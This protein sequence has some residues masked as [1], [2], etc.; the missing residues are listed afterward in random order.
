MIREKSCGAVIWVQEKDTRRYLIERM[1]KGHSSLCKGHMEGEETEHE[2]ALREIGEETALQVTFCGGFR[3][4]ISYSPYPGC[5]KQ[6]VFF[7]AR[8]DQT[9][10]TAQPEEVAQILWLPLEDA[11]KELTHQSDRDVLKK[12]DVWLNEMERKNPERVNDVDNVK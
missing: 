7:L 9:E 12:A 4:T 8:A 1:V 10:V 5:V 6:V 11:M 3:E 2:T